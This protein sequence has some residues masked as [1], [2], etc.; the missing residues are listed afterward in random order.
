[1]QNFNVKVRQYLKENE[2]KRHSRLFGI[3]LSVVMTVSVLASLVM[4][5]ISATEG[6]VASN[7]DVVYDGK[8]FSYKD[9]KNVSITNHTPSGDGKDQT[10]IINFDVAFEFN[11]GEMENNCIYFPIAG[12]VGIP[13]TGIPADGWGDVEDSNYD[14]PDG[15][16]G[17]SGKYKVVKDG[18]QKYLLIIFEEGYKKLNESKGITGNAKFNA[19]VKRQDNETGVSTT[20]TIG[21]KDIVIDGYTALSLSARKKGEDTDEGVKWTITVSNPAKDNL[22]RIE[23]EMFKDALPDTLTVVPAD[24]GHYDSDSGNFVFEEGRTDETVEISY[25]TPYPKNDP[26]F[27][28][29]GKIENKSKVYSD[30]A[31]DEANTT[32]YSKQKTTISEKSGEVNYDTNEVTWTVVVNNPQ[33]GDLKGYHLFDKGFN[34]V[35]LSDFTVTGEDGKN[36]GFTVNGNQLTFGENTTSTKITVKYKTTIGEDQQQ[37][38]N[39]VKIQKP[40]QKDEWEGGDSK[41]ATVYNSYQ[42][43]KSGKA[44]GATGIFTWTINVKSNKDFL[45]GQTVNDTM[46]TKGQEVEIRDAN[47]NVLA[48][49]TVTED[50]KLVLPEGIGDSKDIKIIYKTNANDMTLPEADNN[51]YIKVTNKASIGN[52]KTSATVD[53]KP[54]DEKYKYVK[55]ISQD[56]NTVT[57]EWEL[58]LKQV[59]GAF[60][61]QEI[62]DIMTAGS[63]DGKT[64]QSFLVPESISIEYGIDDSYKQFDDA[65]KYYFVTPS[66]DGKSFTIKFTDDELFDSIKSVRIRYKST[67]DVSDVKVGATINVKNK[68]TFKNKEF[69]P[70][71]D[72]TKYVVDDKDKSPFEKYDANSNSKGDTVYDL[73]ELPVVTIDGVDYY[74]FDWRLDINKEKIYKKDDTV[75]IVDTLPEGMI[76]YDNQDYL[77][78]TSGDSTQKNDLKTS[79][80]FGYTY[81]KSSNQIIFK[82]YWNQQDSWTAYYSTIIKVDTVKQGAVKGSVSYKNTVQDKAKKY[83]EKSQTQ[84]VKEKNITKSSNP[85]STGCDIT[86]TIDVNPKKLGCS[87]SGM[88]TLNDVIKCGGTAVIRTEDAQG[89]EHTKTVSIDGNSSVHLDLKSIEVYDVDTGKALSTSEY[90]YVIHEP[91]TVQ[92]FI[93]SNTAVKNNNKGKCEVY[94][95]PEE[96]VV[97]AKGNI[98]ISLPAGYEGGKIKSYTV[99]YGYMNNGYFTELG[100]LLDN[101]NWSDY[102]S[103]VS[104]PVEIKSIDA[105]KDLVF[106][107]SY[108]YKDK[109]DKSDTA[110]TDANI[111][112]VVT[113]SDLEAQTLDSVKKLEITVP[114]R[115]HLKIVYVYTGRPANSEDAN[116]KGYKVNVFNN[117]S[118]DTKG[119]A[120]NDSAD[121]YSDF[122]LINQSQASSTTKEPF[123]VVKVDSGDYSLMLNASFEIYKYAM[124]ADG[125]YAWLPAVKYTDNADMDRKVVIWGDKDDKAQEFSVTDKEPYNLELESTV[126]TGDT[127]GHLYKLIETKSQEGYQLDS[128]P[129]Y[130]AFKVQPK[131]MPEDVKDYQFIQNGDLFRV[132]NL[133]QE[134]TITASKV[135]SDGNGTHEADNVTFEL[136]SS[137]TKVANGTPDDIKWYDSTKVKLSAE[138]N[139]TYKWDKLPGCVQQAD[140]SYK[141]LYYY[142][143][144]TSSVSGYETVYSANAISRN[145]EVTVNNVKGLTITKEWRDELGNE[146]ADSELPESINSIN[147]IVYES[148]TAPNSSTR[149]NNDKGIP[150]DCTPYRSVTLK[151]T[152]NWKHTLNDLAKDKYYYVLE[153]SVPDGFGV[154]YTYS[155][156]AS[157][158]GFDTIINTKTPKDVKEMSVRLQ[159]A[160]SDSDTKDHANDKVTFNIYRSTNKNDVPTNYNKFTGTMDMGQ[161]VKFKVLTTDGS[162]FTQSGNSIT[163]YTM[164]DSRTFK[165]NLTNF[166][167]N[168]NE[169]ESTIKLIDS[170]GS[171]LAE[172]QKTGAQW[173]GTINANVPTW[174]ITGDRDL[175]KIG[176]YT[177]EN[178]GSGFTLKLDKITSD[179]TVE[180][181]L[182]DGSSST[183]E[184]TSSDPGTAEKTNVSTV[185]NTN[186][187]KINDAFF[188]KAVTIGAT[189][190][191]S[192]AIKLEANDKKGNTYYYWIEEVEV[193]DQPVSTSA[194]KAYYRY[195]GSETYNCIDTNVK[196]QY[197][198][199]YNN[200]E[201]TVGELPETGGRGVLPFA[202]AGGAI[203]AAAT[204]LLVTKR[205][206]KNAENK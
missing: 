148:D 169:S 100:K 193:N 10:K 19:N 79:G 203:T 159:K 30:K 46:L 121:D 188:V 136:G 38:D 77:K 48:T 93:S 182:K 126:G 138:N 65:A 101:S 179:V 20:V 108:D 155:N 16:K 158:T 146:L 150:E 140:G 130:F 201:E 7:A 59:K 206:K 106:K 195:N 71:A 74:R 118:F 29:G 87:T 189:N 9:A 154:T 78:Y 58:D 60:K 185:P 55:Q 197:V 56:G 12:N 88:I 2:R 132:T 167:I 47:D 36:I 67:V 192:D 128:T 134:F 143:K 173:D 33:G 166:W 157:G 43:S 21:G 171:V 145:T 199:V 183:C 72:T 41:T 116:N 112:K 168:S 27:T 151:K 85:K 186:P 175:L 133:L 190:N 81:D 135:W 153:E 164:Y 70:S 152:E 63:S 83:P 161:N 147:V 39:T 57:Y 28:V 8:N 86:Y 75:E 80:Q 149:V 105:D 113:I 95:T 53:Y 178:N 127:E 119:S 14:P 44:D 123:K 24:A 142:I 103:S 131:K 137:T 31:S 115:R 18:D 89:N 204:A 198:Q 17:I 200:Y 82:T 98:N 4:P 49:P 26:N 1:M 76:L 64:I 45:I 162:E 66:A 50:G 32:L 99:S 144:E 11:K 51:G 176:D 62:S 172:L 3:V 52:F 194:Y 165:F 6:T 111:T 202:V 120:V 104:V 69:E 40:D 61:G 92:K 174:T 96:Y 205:R 90:S 129:I 102:G 114:D 68:A 117:I 170:T 177:S 191:W 91:E 73:T 160:W 196:D 181:K 107:V 22:N 35:N 42:I 122:E 15:V 13:D 124:G 184:I 156:N 94:F 54:T 25:V 84:T 97:G 187:D 23:D 109:D 110:V 163:E 5:A 139:W 180:L 141:Q 125:N 34:G 37:L